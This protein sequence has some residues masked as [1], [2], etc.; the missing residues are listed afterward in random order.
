[1]RTEY[2]WECEF[3]LQPDNHSLTDVVENA[4]MKVNVGLIIGLLSVSKS[5]NSK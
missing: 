5:S 2:M 3:I 4:K 1:M